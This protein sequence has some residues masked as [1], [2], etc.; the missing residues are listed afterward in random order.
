[1]SCR[2][3]HGVD[4][5]PGGKKGTLPIGGSSGCRSRLAPCAPA[6]I[7]LAVLVF[8]WGLGY[9]LSLYHQLSRHVS[10][11]TVA[12]LWT[13]TRVSQLLPAVAS[14]QA[15]HSPSLAHAL[16]VTPEASPRLGVAAAVV[17]RVDPRRNEPRG[18]LKLSRSPPSSMPV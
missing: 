14:G 9:K 5:S 8:L 18:S 11:T 2:G 16:S 13:E 6:L 15:Q 17:P 3:S 4:V 1:M 7:A 10:R 12:K